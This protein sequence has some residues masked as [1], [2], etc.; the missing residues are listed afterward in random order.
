MSRALKKLFK[1]AKVSNGHAHRFRHTFAAELLMSAASLTNVA[2]LLGH[3]SSK[4]TEKHYS[5][6]IKGRQEMLEADVHK[7]WALILK[8]L[9]LRDN[10]SLY[11]K[12]ANKTLVTIWWRRGESHYYPV[13]SAR[14][15]FNFHSAANAKTASF[16][17]VWHAP[18]T[19]IPPM[20]II[21]VIQRKR[22]K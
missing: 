9:Q 7:A 15:L 13:L 12:A 14:K 5:S 6:W 4:I 8:P 10:Y 20:I 17:G 22:K 18:G 21:S 16:A 19:R 2:Q 1:L 11:L 3:S